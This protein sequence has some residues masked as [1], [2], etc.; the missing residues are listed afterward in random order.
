[1]KTINPERVRERLDYNPDTGAFVWKH[2]PDFPKSWN[3]RYS[4]RP[5]YC[6][7]NKR[8]Y[9]EGSIDGQMLVGHRVAWAHYY[10]EW[11]KQEIDHIN[12]DRMDN[13][14]ANLRD[15]SHK[16]N[17]RNM[18][19]HKSNTSGVMGVNY[20]KRDKRW[21][22]FIEVLG[23]SIH[24]GNFLE[25]DDAIKARKKAEVEYGFMPEHGKVAA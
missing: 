17:Q 7:P 25:K 12:G 3:T 14:I 15:V 10:G 24:L 21:R 1:M 2:A 8:G 19:I 13:R 18:C 11:P 20:H 4:G 5:A 23:K 6:K 9:A 16:E 22:A